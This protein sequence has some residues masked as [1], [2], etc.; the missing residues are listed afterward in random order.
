[1]K[2]EGTWQLGKKGI[3]NDSVRESRR[4]MM[5]WKRVLSEVKSQRKIYKGL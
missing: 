2:S 5:D 1:V 4:E 3:G